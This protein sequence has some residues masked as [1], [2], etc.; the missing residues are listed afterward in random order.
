MYQIQAVADANENTVVVIHSTGPVLMPWID[1]ENIKAVVWPGL[2]GQETGNSLADV[3]FGDVNPSGRLPYTIAKKEEDYAAHVTPESNIEYTEKLEV[4]Y[5]HFDSSDIEPLFAFGHGLSYSTFEYG[6]IKVNTNHGKKDVLATVT[7]FVKNTG[8]VDGAEVPQ[9]YVSFPES[10]EEP[11]KVL[12]GFERV[13]IK[14]GK[15][16]KVTFEFKEID[17]SIWTEESGWTV[18]E[19]EYTVHVGSSSRDIYQTATFSL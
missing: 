14:S 10:A 8:D 19:G 17:L 4:G 6:N 1:H 13:F 2:P 3:L 12:R 5:R 11:P 15:Q 16:T 18:P 7:A 9:V